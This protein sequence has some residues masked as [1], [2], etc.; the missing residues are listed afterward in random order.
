M[1]ARVE[2]LALDAKNC[3]YRAASAFQ[4]LSNEVDGQEIK[5]GAIYGFL[6]VLLAAW[7]EFGGSVIVA[8]EGGATARRALYPEYKRRKAS[9]SQEQVEFFDSLRRQ[10]YETKH[11]LQ[12]IGVR[13]FYA[14][15]WEADDVIAT[16]CSRF[17][18]H[19]V[20]IL[21][22]DRDL[23][24]LVTDRHRLIRP[25]QKGKIVIETPASIRAEWGVSP[26]QILD[27]KA[28]A[29]DAGDNIPG[30]PGVG[31]KTASKLIA[32]HGGWEEVLR[33]AKLNV[34]QKKWHRSLVE[35]EDKV[36]MSAKLVTLNHKAILIPISPSPEPRRLLSE[37]SR[38]GFQS[39]LRSQNLVAL[40]AMS[41]L[42]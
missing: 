16:V 4:E 32:E 20:G 29:G 35:N 39:L 15:G 2:I 8:W 36:R 30:A 19:H 22:G 23:L 6:R 33:W 5:T 9:T 38:L 37:F 1:S 3:L 40:K 27:L 26:V 11:L 41:A 17:P 31:P 25:L 7:E 12:I 42:T 34:P 21:S 13:Q 28:L 14:D 18:D 10:E 24:Q